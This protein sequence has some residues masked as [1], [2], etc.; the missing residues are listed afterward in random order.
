MDVITRLKGTTE[1]P[2]FL[3]A[4]EAIA[5]QL[6]Y[7]GGSAAHAANS[8]VEAERL[9]ARNISEHGAE[10]AAAEN[11]KLA[12]SVTSGPTLSDKLNTDGTNNTGN[13]S[14]H[15]ARILGIWRR[16][17]ILTWSERR[18]LRSYT[19][20][21]CYELNPALRNGHVTPRQQVR[22]DRIN[23][24]LAKL[25]NYEGV[26][27]RGAIIPV[28]LLERYQPGTVVTEKAFTS[29]SS[30]PSHAFFGN[31]RYNIYSRYGSSVR[32]YSNSPWEREV[33][34]G[35][36]SKFLVVRRTEDPRTEKIEIDMIQL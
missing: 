11:A 14:P 21:G 31:V 22:I 32:R 6:D 17:N 29:T 19:G 4:T 12:P 24:A 20:T 16:E 30:S 34:F 3:Q 5:K 23:S 9:S 8:L 7:L 35:S 2:G 33:L 13:T 15:T 1:H 36:E 28:R 10:I 18:A 26:V 27:Y 25:H